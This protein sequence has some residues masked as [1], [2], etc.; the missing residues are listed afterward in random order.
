MVGTAFLA[1]EPGAQPFV[2]AGSR[3][4]AGDT[5]LIVEAM[6]VMNPITAPRGGTIKKVFVQDSQP[7]EYDQP[8]LILE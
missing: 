8:L 7:V 3:V 6:K 4:E 1:P 5:L 2:S